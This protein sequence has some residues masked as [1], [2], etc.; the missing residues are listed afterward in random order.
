MATGL[1][2]QENLQPSLPGMPV[3]TKPLSLVGKLAEACNSVGGLEK[4]GTNTKQGYKYLKA[5]D[6]AKAIRGEFFSRGILLTF[7]EKKFTQL[8]TIPTNSGGTMGEFLLE[9]EITFHDADSGEK[10]GPYGAF[11]VAMDTGDKAIWKCKTGA[12]KYVLRGI[13]LI[14]DEKD[15]PEADEKVDQAIAETEASANEAKHL[16]AFEQRAAAAP[17]EIEPERPKRP[18]AGYVVITKVEE[19]ITAKKAIYWLLSVEPQGSGA[20]YKVSVWDSKLRIPELWNAA[21]KDAKIEVSQ[22]V[23]GDKTYYT[24]EKIYVLG[25]KTFSTPALETV[26]PPHPQDGDYEFTDDD[27]Y[28]A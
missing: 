4:K 19:K 12:L 28:R 1:G 23:K 3:Q 7:D 5:A 20:S 2:A 18:Q 17:K 21:G 15:D 8:R 24:L 13:G 11:G 26:P 10:L 6:V 22:Q 9:A 14:P 25:A 27:L 16:T